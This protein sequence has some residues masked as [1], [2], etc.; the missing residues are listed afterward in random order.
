MATTDGHPAAP[1]RTIPAPATTRSS[2]RTRRAYQRRK[3]W[4]GLAYLAPAL[5]AYALVVI[6]PTVQGGYVS[7]FHWDG[8]TPATW[9]GFSNYTGFLSDPQLRQAVEH[10]LVFIAFFAVLPIT[11]GLLTAALT[12]RKDVRGAAVYRWVLFL[13][14]VLTPAVTAIVWKRIYAPDGPVNSVLRAFG[15]EA[16]TRGWLSDYT[17]ALPALGLAG[18]WAAFGLCTVLFVSGTQSIPTELYDAV[19]VDGA[20]AV[21]EFFTVTLPGLRGQLAV[22]LTLSAL[23]AIRVFDIVWLTTRGGP[24]TST[25]TPTIVLYQR[26]FANPD[27]GTAAAVGVVLAA[28]SLAVA[29]VILKLS[30]DRSR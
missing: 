26:A 7:L 21:R 5:A 20:G 24:G 27:I 2:A 23:G 15:L 12:S 19:R 25:I 18:T 17:W 16:L 1:P 30:E 28:V 8:V 10:T 3:P 11:L 14:Q 6:V 13:P 4:L 9:A 29:L 22:A